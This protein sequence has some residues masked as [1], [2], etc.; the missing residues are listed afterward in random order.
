MITER[1]IEGN[2]VCYH[3]RI[4]VKYRNGKTGV[5]TYKVNE[6]SSDFGQA[7]AVGKVVR[8]YDNLREQKEIA[9]YRILA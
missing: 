2:E 9:D 4:M 3:F 8:F 5:E 7:V 1:V 6:S